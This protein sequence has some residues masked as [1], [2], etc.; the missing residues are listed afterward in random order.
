MTAIPV[1]RPD[2]PQAE[3][4]RFR[5][6]GTGKSTWAIDAIVIDP[7]DGSGQRIMIAE[8]DTMRGILAEASA[9][10]RRG[11]HVNRGGLAK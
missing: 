6:R 5:D 10:E 9:L 11:Y 7:R 8:A 4:V 3:I 1:P 2:K